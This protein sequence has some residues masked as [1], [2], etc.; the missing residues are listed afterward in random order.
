[1]NIAIVSTLIIAILNAIHFYDAEAAMSLEQIQ[2][3]MNSLGK[4]CASK[5]GI[6][7]EIQEAHKRREFPEDRGLMCYF[8]CMMKM[9]KVVDK[10]SKIDV[11]GTIAQMRALL[12]DDIKESGV[13]AFTKCYPGVL[14]LPLKPLQ[15]TFAVLKI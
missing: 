11:D 4:T 1:M 3:M 6:T 12:P 14:F 8:S 10:N 5:S 13:A 9:T 7:P 15:L 2:K